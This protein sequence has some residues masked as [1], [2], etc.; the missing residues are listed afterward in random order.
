MQDWGKKDPEDQRAQI[1]CS[2][3]VGHD[4]FSHKPD[5]KILYFTGP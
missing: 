4:A 3:M 2:H 5:W 1:K